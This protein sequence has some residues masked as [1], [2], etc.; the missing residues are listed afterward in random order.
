M[1]TRKNYIINHRTS[2]LVSHYEHTNEYTKVM[3]GLESF[4]VLQ[5]PDEIVRQSF[6]YFGNN[7]E[8]A[9]KSARK[10]LNK[11][12]PIPITLSAAH[13]LFLIRCDAPNQNG[14]VWLI[15]S[16]IEEIQRYRINQTTVFLANGP[17]IQVDIKKRILQDQLRSASYLSSSLLFKPVP[18]KTKHYIYDPK[19]GIALV[20]EDGQLNYIE[21]R[22][23]EDDEDKD[24]VLK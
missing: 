9:L 21:R 11:H 17:S 3:H 10:I 8:D 19:K 20:L 15:C 7:L 14:V 12:D 2:A 5:P 23:K 18:H 4:I 13:N 22:N 24:L 16:Q 6:H 1:N